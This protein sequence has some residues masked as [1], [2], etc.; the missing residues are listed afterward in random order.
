MFCTKCGKEYPD[1]GQCTCQQQPQPQ[2]QPQ[3]P[4]QQQQPQQRPPQPQ[5]PQQQQQ[6]QQRPPQ[7]QQ[8]QQ[9]QY[10]QQPQQQFQ[11]RQQPQQPQQQF[12]QP[13]QQYQQQ[14]QQQ[15]YQQQYQQPYAPAD[16]RK[17]YCILAYIPVLF[18]VGMLA[19]NE[20]NDPRVRFHVGQGIMLSIYWAAVW[21]VHIII[22]MVLQSVWR[23][24]TSVIW[25]YGYSSPHIGAVLVSWL[26][27][28]VA[29]GS[30]A[31]LAVTAIMNINKNRDK[32]LPIIGGLAFYK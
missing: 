22:S 5:Q 24:T 18:L 9:Q 21:I 14:P 26:I 8:Y 32:P 12:Q 4:Q 20:K 2:Q 13:Q 25:G 30:V 23:T 3:Q 10:Q 6:P 7:Q 27:W 17:L 19:S 28:L 15:Q 11:Q 1:G 16:N 29:W 31:F